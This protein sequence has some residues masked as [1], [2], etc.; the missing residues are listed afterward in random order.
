MDILKIPIDK[1]AW[2]MLYDSILKHTFDIRL[3]QLYLLYKKEIEY[4]HII[5]TFNVPLHTEHVLKLNKTNTYD[6]CYLCSIQNGYYSISFSINCIK[7]I[8]QKNKLKI[9]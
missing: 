1:N 4:T 9:N 8:I 3:T 7:Y 6:F 2:E 5:L